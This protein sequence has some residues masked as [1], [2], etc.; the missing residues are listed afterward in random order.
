M[1]KEEWKE[2][3]SQVDD[4]FWVMRVI[5]ESSDTLSSDSFSPSFAQ[6][7]LHFRT[8]TTASHVVPIGIEFQIFITVMALNL[9]MHLQRLWLPNVC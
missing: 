2:L 3:R 1:T 8:T 9:R 7:T 5:G 4:S 6:V